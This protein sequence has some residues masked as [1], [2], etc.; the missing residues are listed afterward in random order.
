MLEKVNNKYR[1]F[2][3]AGHMMELRDFVKAPVAA[4]TR[5]RELAIGLLTEIKGVENILIKGK[6]S[7]E[8]P[9]VSIEKSELEYFET[10][11]LTDIYKITDL[12][13]KD[14]EITLEV[15]TLLS[16]LWGGESSEIKPAQDLLKLSLIRLINEVLIQEDDSCSEDYDISLFSDQVDFESLSDI[17]VCL[18]SNYFRPQEWLE[19]SRK[20]K[21]LFSKKDV[22][23][24]PLRVR[25]R[26]R[27]AYETYISGYNFACIAT[28]RSLLEYALV[29]RAKTNTKWKMNPYRE[30][31]DKNKRELKSLEELCTLFSDISPGLDKKLNDIRLN[32]N[33]VLHAPAN[34]KKEEFPPQDK[35]ARDCLVSVFEV[36]E[37][38]YT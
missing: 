36:I 23:K 7:S 38:I 5:I 18:N 19:R 11:V 31:V 32:G 4:K 27:E 10:N 17:L 13:S 2:V 1:A 3:T 22:G 28:C 30:S 25:G 8:Y 21:F 20:A 33:R 24:Y 34:N 29:D 15:Q 37:E 6:L 16:D 35:T 9:V 12:A 14:P 26:I